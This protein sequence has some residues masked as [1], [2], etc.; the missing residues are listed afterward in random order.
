[1]VLTSEQRLRADASTKTHTASGHRSEG[2]SSRRACEAHQQPGHAPGKQSRG[3][4]GD[5]GQRQPHAVPGHGAAPAEHG[6]AAPRLTTCGAAIRAS[7]SPHRPAPNTR[8]NPRPHTHWRVDL[9][10]GRSH[11]GTKG[12]PPSDRQQRR[13]IHVRPDGHPSEARR[14]ATSPVSLETL[15]ARTA[16]VHGHMKRPEGTNPR[17][18]QWTGGCQGPGCPGEV[19][20]NG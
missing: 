7:E 17:D 18:A 14:P 10:P 6:P 5:R 3:R 16:Q 20:R 2:R 19:G 1:M 11:R 8:E 9:H 12:E 4:A 13:Q 15:R